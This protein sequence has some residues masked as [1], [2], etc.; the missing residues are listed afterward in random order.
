MER[1]P[2]DLLPLQV[3]ADDLKIS[4]DK[5][6]AY[7]I[8]GQLIASFFGS[9]ASLLYEIHRECNDENEWVV[10]A[11]NEPEFVVNGIYDIVSYREV[12]WKYT[13]S[14]EQITADL[15]ADKV[16]LFRNGKYYSTVCEYSIN[17]NDLIVT[18]QN[19]K[20]FVPDF[21]TRIDMYDTQMANFIVPRDSLVELESQHGMTKE[22]ARLILPPDVTGRRGFLKALILGGLEDFYVTKQEMP[23]DGKAFQ[24]FMDFIHNRLHSKPR[25]EYLAQVIK[26][27]KTGGPD[28]KCICRNTNKSGG[29]WYT[30]RYVEK[31]FFTYRKESPFHSASPPI[32]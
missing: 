6:E 19:I 27:L 22:G 28:E 9:G 12:N 21:Y 25:P 24:N 1:P 32:T 18:M 5:L 17:K 7:L 30:R 8:S 2:A 26:L 11:C 31:R 3:F 13:E 15:N 29:K 14:T 10:T 20:D 23:E 4:V 16:L